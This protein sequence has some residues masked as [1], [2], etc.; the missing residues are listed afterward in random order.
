MSDSPFIGEIQLLPY[1]FVP[2]G[3]L[4]CN[5]SALPISQ[6]QTLFAV[7]GTTY[8]GDGRSTFRLPN[9]MDRAPMHSG[10]GPGLTPRHWGEYG[11][12]SGVALTEGQMPSHRHSAY[13]A[14]ATADESAPTATRFLGAGKTGGPFPGRIQPYAPAGTDAQFADGALATAGH[15]QPHE[16]RQPFLSLGVVIAWD[17]IFPVHS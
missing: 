4:P 14:T 9:L 5:G 3:W 12:E 13:A 16:N 8:G 7:I 1:Q 10:Q 17:S 11:G 2:R 6:Y 15:G